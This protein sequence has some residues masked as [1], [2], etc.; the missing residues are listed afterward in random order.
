MEIKMLRTPM[1]SNHIAD[2]GKMVDFA[3]WELPVHYGSMLNE[4][5][6]CRTTCGMFDAS[7]MGEILV[8]GDGALPFLQRLVTNNLSKLKVGRMQYNM[9]LDHMGNVLDDMMIYRKSDNSF[10]CVVNASNTPKIWNWMV[11]N[12]TSN[13]SLVDVSPQVALIAIQG[14]L[15]SSV[16]GQVLP[17]V[18]DLPYM[19][20][21]FLKEKGIFLLSRSGYTGEDGYEIYL[22]QKDAPSL[23]EELRAAGAKP[24]G[25]G[26]RDILRM[27]VGYPLYG[28]EIDDTIDPLEA[29]L[30]WAVDFTHEFI[31]KCKLSSKNRLIRKRIGFV[32]ED[33]IPP[34]PGYSIMKN[35]S[36][37]GVV[38]SGTFSPN[39]N[40]SIG[41]GFVEVSN[42][43]EGSSLEI[44]IREK[45]YNANVVKLPFILPYT[46][47]SFS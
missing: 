8:D 40:K 24:C 45:S 37:I 6:T 41:M 7:H 19:N 39:L 13:V 20:F 23:W 26:S 10:M 2:V 44:K 27:E 15:S 17:N 5:I 21:S 36:N 18:L 12:K 46:K 16:I 31:G 11:S 28:H 42:S 9:M 25:L 4:A 1:Y 22:D 33:R 30:G 29:G 47:K 14:P 35:G 3:G 38:T 43:K 34:R 32:M